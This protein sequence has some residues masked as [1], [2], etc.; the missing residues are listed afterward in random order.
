MGTLGETADIGLAVPPVERR[1]LGG[2][3]RDHPEAEAEHA[4]EQRDQQSPAAHAEEPT[5]T[6]A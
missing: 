6:P 5:G 4:A 3:R 1:R 2:V